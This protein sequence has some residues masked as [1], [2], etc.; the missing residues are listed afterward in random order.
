MFVVTI[1]PDACSGCGECTQSCPAQILELVEGKA[2]VVG[3]DCLGCQSC[4][5]LCQAEAIKVDEY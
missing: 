5:G 2:T 4:S 1:D 3:E